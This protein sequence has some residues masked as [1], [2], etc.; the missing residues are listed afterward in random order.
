MWK[1]AQTRFMQ[2]SHQNWNV[3]RTH[4]ER[5]IL[6]D[7]VYYPPVQWKRGNL[8]KKKKKR[9]RKEKKRKKRYAFEISGDLRGFHN[10]YTDLNRETMHL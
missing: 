1:F 3:T 9:K 10:S 7:F 2:V 5:S 6:Y 8:K 4:H